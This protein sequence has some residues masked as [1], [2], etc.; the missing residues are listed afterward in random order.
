VGG[1]P[2]GWLEKLRERDSIADLA[3]RLISR[4]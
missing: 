2:D 4:G 3:V 1:I